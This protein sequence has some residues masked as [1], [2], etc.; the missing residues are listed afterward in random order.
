MAAFISKKQMR[1]VMA[2]LAAKKK[3]L[4]KSKSTGKGVGVIVEIPDGRIL[5]GRASFYGDGQWSLPGGKV[6]VGESFEEAARR[7]LREETGLD[8][9][10]N[11]LQVLEDGESEKSFFVRFQATPEFKPFTNELSDIGF[12]HISDLLSRNVRNCS[13]STIKKWVESHLK[14]S[15]RLQDMV[16]KEVL[17]KNI[18]RHGQVSDVVYELSH[19]DA[20]KLVGNGTFRIIQNAVKGMGDD[21]IK[22]VKFGPY[23]LHIRKHVNDIYS[24][25]IDDGLKTIH[26][27]VNRSLPA[28]TAELMSVFE[29]YSDDDIK[30]QIDPKLSDDVIDDGISKLAANYTKHNLENIH[31]EMENIREEI[32]Q[33]V[34]VDIQQA[35]QKI[36]KLFDSLE[37]R[38]GIFR[39]KHN[40][41]A[42]SAG[43]DLDEIE[44]KLRELQSK[45]DKMPQKKTTVKGVS[46]TETDP[47][48]VHGEMY[49]YLSK[50]SITIEPNG[51]ITITF[52]QDW[53]SM[54]K[55]NFIS[56][57]KVKV[58]KR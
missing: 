45:V 56:D 46:S 57:L 6:E 20:L 30:S 12:Y 23:T 51:R 38:M 4:K 26:Q 41:L 9:N 42:E 22:D 32:R 29:W 34:A 19:G 14:K 1:M 35:E 25:R 10:S 21:T 53:D 48:K 54:E 18:I 39:D 50:P 11:S 27:F 40:S 15:N 37:E 47:N 16:A 8:I 24:G 44:S 36:M 43:R 58:S 17:A 13:L 49:P 5:A 55:S 3:D 33:G 2:I 7:E 52:G 31:Q 28:L